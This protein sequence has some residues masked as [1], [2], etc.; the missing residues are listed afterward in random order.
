MGLD[1]QAFE[2]TGGCECLFVNVWVED[3]VIAQFL[4]VGY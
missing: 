1:R 3:E 2:F 4:L